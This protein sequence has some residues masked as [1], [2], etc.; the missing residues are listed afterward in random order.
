MSW[1]QRNC[2]GNFD[3]EIVQKPGERI[4]LFEVPEDALAFSLIWKK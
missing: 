1:C 4:W 2:L 3:A